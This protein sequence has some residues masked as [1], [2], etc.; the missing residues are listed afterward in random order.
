MFENNKTRNA[1]KDLIIDKS[2]LLK[3]RKLTQFSSIPDVFG[4]HD[5]LMTSLAKDEIKNKKQKTKQE[6]PITLAQVSETQQVNVEI[7]NKI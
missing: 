7:K 6:S 3:T 1:Y 2:S 4:Q 5:L